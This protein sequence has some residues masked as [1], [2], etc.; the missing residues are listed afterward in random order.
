M[1]YAIRAVGIEFIKFGRAT[2]IGRRLAELDT[3][4]PFELEIIAT[5]DWPDGSETAIHRLLATVNQKGEWF[6]DGEL[7]Q[8]IIKWMSNVDLGL[9]RLQ[10]ELRKQLGVSFEKKDSGR[11]RS[12]ELSLA[13]ARE[14]RRGRFSPSIAAQRMLQAQQYDREALHHRS[15]MD[16]PP[17]GNS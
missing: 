6:R 7:A 15:V 17:V 3:G 10:S 8:S 2:S 5:A 11:S 1:I 13:P 12:G 4:C 16:A 14:K 9:A